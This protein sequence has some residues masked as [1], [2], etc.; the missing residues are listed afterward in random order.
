MGYF[1]TRFVMIVG[2]EL[3]CCN[4]VFLMVL[5]YSR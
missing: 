1:A 2:Q 4:A 5:A 3:R